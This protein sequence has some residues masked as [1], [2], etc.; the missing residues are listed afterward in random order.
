MYIFNKELKFR[1]F[2]TKY[3]EFKFKLNFN[4]KIIL[5]HN[6]IW[7]LMEPES[8]RSSTDPDQ[9][10]LGPVLTQFRLV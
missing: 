5:I 9:T 6:L 2:L 7:Y 4:G 1:R 3:C 10:G 8:L